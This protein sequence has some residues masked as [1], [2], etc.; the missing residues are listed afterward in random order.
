MLSRSGEPV[1]DKTM[2]RL[3]RRGRMMGLLLAGVVASIALTLATGDGGHTTESAGTIG[4]PS[5]TLRPLPELQAPTTI[6]VRA[7][8]A[9][10]LDAIAAAA[11]GFGYTVTGRV[12]LPPALRIVPPAG[13]GI[14]AAV[15]VFAAGPSVLYAEPDYPLAQQDV[16]KD[17][18]YAKEAPYLT[19][20]H[21]PEAWDITKGDPGV[22]VAVLDTGVDMTHPDLQG[23]FWTNAG[24][25]INSVDD[26]DNGCVDDVHGCAFI[27]LPS[28]GCG[29]TAGSDI[30]DDVGH[31]TFISGIIAAGG[32]NGIGMVGVARGVT[33]MPVKVLDCT[34]VGATFALAQG[35]L[36]AAA[37]GARI[38]NIS[39][40]GPLDSALL[41]EAVRIAHDDY[42]ALIVAATGNE[43]TQVSYPA[44]YPSVLAVGAASGSNPNAR[45]DFSGAGPEVGV[46]AIG[47]GIIGTVPKGT[48]KTFLPCID[49]FDTYATGDG[50]SFSAPQVAGLA[51]L[52]LSRNPRLTPDQVISIIKATA[53]PLPAGDRPGWAGAGR[54]NMLKALVPQFRIGA[55]GT[56]RSD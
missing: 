50:T 29:S 32:G 28:P 25:T 20:E 21:A 15:T 9:G 33:I 44:R 36:Y 48:C 55:P 34:G 38:L 37:N 17:P 4:R 56:A 39:L 22:V 3:I 7:R 46:V 10:D 45:A 16:P 18:L 2:D 42:G 1:E 5:A 6:I 52:M 47:E 31:G 49:K 35:I 19:V 14:E 54:I 43:P 41:R 53:D 11:A 8:R 40:G 51:A 30:H 24:E 12:E 27:P 23:R 26:D 13:I